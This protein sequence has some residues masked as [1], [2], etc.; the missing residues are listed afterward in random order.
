MSGRA[1]FAAWLAA[2]CLQ[3]STV[4]AQS[5]DNV[6]IIAND[7]VPGSVGIAER[8]AA[9]R[10]VPN[11]QLLR[12]TA[13][14]GEQ[15]SPAEFDQQLQ[16][17]VARW[18]AAHAAQ[19]RILYI[20]LTRGVPLRIS[21]SGGRSG[22]ASSVDS[23]LALLYRRLSGIPVPL[24]GPIPNPYYAG[25]AD[26]VDGAKPFS[27]ASHDIYLVT[28][29][30][31]FTVDD[32]AALIERGA[33]PVTE[34]RILLDE[35][36]STSD[37]RTGWV[38][39]A[40]SRLNAPSAGDR[41]VLETTTRALRNETGVLGYVSRGSNDP[42]L[43]GRHPGLTFVPGALASMFL[44]TD[45]RTFVEPPPDW[46]PGVPGTLNRYAGSSQSLV[47]DL[48]RN[49]I[50]GVA[51]QVA[52][53]YLD[54]TV[55]PDIL[56]PAY[57]QGFNLAESFYLATPYLSW[58][59]VIVGDPLCAPFRAASLPAAQADPPMDGETQLPVYYAARRLAALA[60]QGTPASVK[61]VLLAGSR[62]DRGDTA[63]AIEALE[64]AVATDGASLLAWRSLAAAYQ[65]ARRFT[66]AK[67][68]YERI[69]T[70]A[71][72]DAV[73]LNN[74]AYNLAVH[75]NQPRDAL[76]L[77][78]RAASLRRDDPTIDDTLG[79]IHHLLGN[80]DLALP[81]LE[82]A[83]RSLPQNAEI[84]FHAA[85]AYGAAGRLDDAAKALKIAAEIDPTLKERS[86]FRDLLRVIGQRN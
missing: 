29:L 40:A 80:N 23:E 5:G 12:V 54:G 10:H 70:L 35:P 45:A 61:L 72:D 67:R 56:F 52:E 43:S 20:V 9:A 63:A 13:G 62:A 22:T 71:P 65:T 19:D 6:L 3:V 47:A 32:A 73:S 42:A 66:D 81:L 37:V 41:A 17:P 68:A 26:Q 77:A 57:L 46:Q 49:G 4:R 14:S 84:Q 83:C 34:G 33:H 60:K 11:D 64:K 69:L 55:R 16:R 21:G 1:L 2:S 18:L 74:L 85:I 50:T 36:S 78:I 30:D 24:T 82:R 58:Q 8:Y 39:A 76:P 38:K 27:H 25:T 28:R 51:G 59:T 15:L 48:V 75:E 7:A 86:D 31:G 53:P 44:S 79:W